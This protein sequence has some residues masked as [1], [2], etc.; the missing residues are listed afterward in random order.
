M[1]LKIRWRLEMRLKGLLVGFL[2]LAILVVASTIALAAEEAA[3]GG[4]DSIALAA[5]FI[6]AGLA[7]GI[8]TL[9]PAIGQGNAVRGACEGMARNPGVAGK[10]LTTMLLGLAMM[11]SLAIYALVVALILLFANPFV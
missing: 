3:E 1:A 4:K 5:I 7:M 2:S 11:E 10:L 6:A 8:G 9:G